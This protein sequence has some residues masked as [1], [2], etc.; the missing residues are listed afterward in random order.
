VYGGLDLCL[1][2]VS[3]EE[4]NVSDPHS[5][6]A[7]PESKFFQVYPSFGDIKMNISIFSLLFIVI[8]L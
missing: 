6:H 3:G 5:F 8:C 4:S 1:G 7:D 2:R